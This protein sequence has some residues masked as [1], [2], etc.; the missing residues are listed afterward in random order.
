MDGS[1]ALF[2]RVMKHAL[3]LGVML[4]LVL[5][6][7][8]CDGEDQNGTPT[9]TDHSTEAGVRPEGQ[10]SA[11]RSRTKAHARPAAGRRASLA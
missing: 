10:R 6:V 9:R 8:G 1:L 5:L 11:T 4:G 7:I 3:G 2:C